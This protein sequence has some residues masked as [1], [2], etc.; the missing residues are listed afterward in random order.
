MKRTILFLSVLALGASLAARTL[1][2]PLAVD[3][4]NHASYQWLGKAVSF[5]L[6]VGLEQNSLPACEEEEVRELLNRNWVR[7]PYDITK[8]TAL[9]LAEE[10]GAD[11][12][13]WGKVLYSDRKTAQM[14]V[15]LFL[16]DV[17]RT[18]Q[19]V[20]PLVRGGFLEM[21]RLQ[22]DLLRQVLH[23]VAPDRRETVLP[24]LNMTL[25]E[26]ERF[27]KS[28]LLA[29]AGKKLELLAPP[30]AASRSDF[31]HLELAKAYLEKGN[32]AAGRAH[33]ER[34][35]DA[36]YFLDRKEFFL[37]LADRQSGASAA[38]LNRFIRLQQRNAFPAATHNNLGVLYLARG[39]FALAE[40]CLRY[41]LSL[42]RDSGILAN[43][44]LLLRAMGREDAAR[45]ELALA[46]RRFPEDAR[47]LRLF[48]EALAV[49]ENGGELARAFRDHLALPLPEDGAP[50]VE[51]QVLGPGAAVP[52]GED[53]A[54][55]L[56]YIEARN[57]FLE[58]DF[59]GAAQKAEEAM[60][61]NPFLAET[62]HLL[63]LLALRQGQGDRAQLFSQSALF[64][65]E[66]LDN[67]LLRLKVHETAGDREGF[68]V[69]LERALRKFPR[70]PE[71]L[72][73]A[74]RGR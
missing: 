12:L 1:V 70:S 27:I 22:E 64:L 7:F 8:A 72:E 20:L 29:D 31:V 68:R 57:L 50:G 48:A 49:A 36:P 44:V 62:H 33:L 61:G 67:F 71:L 56:P 55:S 18:R 52:A 26:Y 4:Q 15:Q 30:A 45:Q 38:A 23:A 10:A 21:F 5:F 42:R 69:T 73:R 74:G 43:L 58:N 60:E 53:A 46:L 13:M 47:L 35:G 59:D 40:Q 65:S 3:T 32:P 24:R 25:P 54:A 41:A 11:R 14:Q 51:A 9:V 17:G 39:E 2:L 16:L 34:L 28:L 37:A 66:T 19:D 6:A 63:A